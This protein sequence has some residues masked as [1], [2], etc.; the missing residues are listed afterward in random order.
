MKVYKE[1][2]V[3]FW[4]GVGDLPRKITVGP[5]AIRLST[6]AMYKLMQTCGKRERKAPQDQRSDSAHTVG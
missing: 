3:L 4:R 1:L 2:A 5:K 6:G